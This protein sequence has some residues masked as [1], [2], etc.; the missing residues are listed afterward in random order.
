MGSGHRHRYIYPILKYANEENF[1][2]NRFLTNLSDIKIESDKW[3]DIQKFWNNINTAF[4][5]TLA[6]NKGIGLY[7]ELTSRQN[8]KD[9]I[10]LLVGNTKYNIWQASYECFPRIIKDHLTKKN[11]IDCDK[12]PKA[13]KTFLRQQAQDDGFNIL[14]C[15]IIEGSF[16]LDGE[17][18]DLINYVATLNMKHGE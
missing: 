1:R 8:I 18:R 2:W 10:I 12:S 13:F 5:S 14:T 15:I 7:K 11:V 17:A 6:T 16:H 9:C 3:N 4:C